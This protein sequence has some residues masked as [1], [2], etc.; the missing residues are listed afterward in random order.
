MHTFM[1][2]QRLAIP[3]AV[4][5]LVTTFPT[6]ASAQALFNKLAEKAAQKLAPA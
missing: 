5:M 3:L 1:K 6:A 4:V 2:F